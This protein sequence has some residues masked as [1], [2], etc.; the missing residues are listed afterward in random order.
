MG[1]T[2]SLL[3]DKLTTITKIAK[4]IS[5]ENWHISF[6]RIIRA[7][8]SNMLLIHFIAPSFCSLWL[9][10]KKMKGEVRCRD[11]K[12]GQTDDLIY[13]NQRQTFEKRQALKDASQSQVTIPAGC[14]M[15]AYFSKK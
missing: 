11:I 8:K 4:E 6:A 10:V 14:L 3:N 5:F 12:D 2:H 7:R 9:N 1:L 15:D 13:V